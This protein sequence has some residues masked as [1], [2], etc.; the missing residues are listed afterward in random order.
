MAMIQE[1]NLT[2]TKQNLTTTANEEWARQL[3]E[4]V[5]ANK[6]AP[7]MRATNWVAP[8][9]PTSDR[10]PSWWST[11]PERNPV[12]TYPLR[13]LV[14]LPGVVVRALFVYLL[15]VPI[16]CFAFMDLLF[17]LAHGESLLG[18]ALDVILIVF[19]IGLV[20]VS[21]V[22]VVT[23]TQKRKRGAESVT[24]TRR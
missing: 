12:R 14:Q 23:E 6:H 8:A 11:K 16:S 21:L 20:V 15:G 18:P 2:T 9:P 17:F 19:G 10:A 3:Y 24:W 7:V 1:L 5:L 13:N 22:A 4:A